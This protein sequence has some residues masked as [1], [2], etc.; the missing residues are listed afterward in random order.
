MTRNDCFTINGREEI[1]CTL[2]EH[3]IDQGAKVIAFGIDDSDKIIVETD[4]QQDDN[5]Y[6]AESEGTY[7][8]KY[9]VDNLKYG[10][11]FKVQKIRLVTFVEDTESSEVNN[12]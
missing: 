5:G 3:Y 1:T 2:S 7:Y 11:I 6:Y 4:L 10:R 9:T 8:I 12:V